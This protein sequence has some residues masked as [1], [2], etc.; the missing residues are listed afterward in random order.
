MSWSLR[1]LDHAAQD[2]EAVL[3]VTWRSFGEVQYEAYRRLIHD[4]LVEIATDP[5]GARVRARPEI[6]EQARTLHIGRIG[7]PARHF[8]L[9]RIA[10][11]NVVEVARL[12]HDRMEIRRHVQESF[13]D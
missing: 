12:L 4:A 3:T 2:I 11:D 10:E 5:C 7:K 9:F 13:D 1:I 6:H 8:F